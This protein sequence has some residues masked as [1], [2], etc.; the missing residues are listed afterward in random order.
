[1]SD[2]KLTILLFVAFLFVVAVAMCAKAG[3]L[4]DIRQYKPIYLMTHY[5]DGEW[6]DKE[7]AP[8]V[9]AQISFAVPALREAKSVKGVEFVP[10]L[11]FTWVA[12]NWPVGAESSPIDENNYAPE[13]FLHFS[14]NDTSGLYRG[15][16]T[17]WLHTSTGT[18]SNSGS[19]DRWQLETKFALDDL[20]FIYVQGWF[21]MDYGMETE[22]IKNYTN[23]AKLQDFGGK[24]LIAADLS[25]I[26]L[27]GTL[28][29]SWQ[30]LEAFIP[31]QESYNLYLYGQFHNG[32]AASLNRYAE[33]ETSGGVGVALLR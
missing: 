10:E 31:L 8:Y 9:K 28:G 32:N 16:T 18:D 20:L 29:L 25:M 26:R 19:W 33:R 17:G 30:E 11:A 13:I 4:Q 27:A 1:M 12:Q 24:V 21:V 2:R 15:F 3:P 6:Y 7:S 14:P 5:S 23:F 22:P